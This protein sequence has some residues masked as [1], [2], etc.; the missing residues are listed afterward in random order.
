MHSNLSFLFNIDNTN[1]YI[2]FFE[3]GDLIMKNMRVYGN[4]GV[5]DAL[6]FGFELGLAFAVGYAV[7]KY[8]VETTKKYISEKKTDNI[9]TLNGRLDTEE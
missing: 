8:G 1:L 5:K 6:T 3:S 4:I 9:S 2:L 7:G